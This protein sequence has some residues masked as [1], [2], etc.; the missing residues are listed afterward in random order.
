MIQRI[1]SLFGRRTQELR[2]IDTKE[3]RKVVPENDDIVKAVCSQ[4]LFGGEKMGDDRCPVCFEDWT[5]G[6]FY[7]ETN[8]GH[9]F[10]GKCMEQWFERQITCPKCRKDLL[11]R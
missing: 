10:C 3:S 1:R 11:L 5:Y 8:C 9:Q 6:G 7:V 2:T 4:K